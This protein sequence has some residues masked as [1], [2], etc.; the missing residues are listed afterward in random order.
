MTQPEQQEINIDEPTWDD[1]PD[2]RGGLKLECGSFVL[3]R[4]RSTFEF[5]EVS[6]PGKGNADMVVC[7]KPAYE[8]DS[9][10]PKYSAG[11]DFYWYVR[12]NIT[13]WHHNE[14]RGSGRSPEEAKRMAYLMTVGL[15]AGTN[16]GAKAPVLAAAEA[17]AQKGELRE[18][19]HKLRMVRYC[20]EEALARSELP[21]SI[22]S[23]LRPWLRLRRPS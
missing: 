23:T 2:N 13:G 10:G 8:D 20:L 15:Y 19:K 18:L 14:F 4:D 1:V 22:V 17:A 3:D 21:F 12:F 16:A 5:A 11:W 9:K 6:F 7:V